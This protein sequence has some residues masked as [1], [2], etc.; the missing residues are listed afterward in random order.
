MQQTRGGS[1]AYFIM[2]ACALWLAF[3]AGLHVF[4]LMFPP[5]P[6]L[7]NAAAALGYNIKAAYL[8]FVMIAVW[9]GLGLGY[10]GPSHAPPAPVLAE[11]NSPTL[12]LW[13]E[14]VGLLSGI[15]VLYWPPALARF[16]PHIEAD[17]FISTLW[18]V[19]CGQ[20]PYTDFEFLYGPLMIGLAEAWIS[21]TGFSMVSYYTYYMLLQ[22]VFFGLLLLVLQGHVREAWKRYV[23]LLLL[24]PFVLDSLLGLNWMALRYF[25][26]P[27]MILAISARPQCRIRGLLAGCLIGTQAALSYEYGII[28]LATAMALYGVQLFYPGRS[29]ALMAGGL[30]AAGGVAVWAGLAWAS[31]G[32]GFDDYLSMT[33]AVSERSGA[34]GLGQF[35][36]H[37]TV[38]TLAL[39]LVLCCALV[40]F[41]SGLR[42]LGRAPLTAGDLHLIGALV[43]LGIAMRVAL[44][45]ADYVHMAIPFVPLIL[46]LLL[47]Q[48]RSLL[49]TAP[50]LQRLAI[51]A[52]VVAAVTHAVGQ[53]YPGKWIL[54]NQARGLAQELRGAPVIGA[55]PARNT[56][57]HGERFEAVAHVAE[58]AALLAEPDLAKRPVLFYGSTWDWAPHTGVCPA[59]YSFYDLLYANDRYPHSRLLAENPDLLIVIPKKDFARLQAGEIPEVSIRQFTDHRKKLTWLTSPHY[60]QG[61]FENRAEHEM[62]RESIGDALAQQFQPLAEIDRFLLL[63]RK[64]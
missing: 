30:A 3:I 32:G 44:Q 36:F 33:L 50:V 21:L 6:S 16:G 45:R 43:F 54:V 52:A 4:P 57:I 42:R 28:A 62:W 60:Q 35:A 2:L 11:P 27:L 10:Y 8:V 56:G 29:K 13:T 26:V 14:R 63:A 18:R 59:G 25:L 48:P 41:S 34:L 37:W 53:T 51:A 19:A 22:L 64:P 55:I 49:G 31:T 20:A 5:D 46:V 15:A 40:M 38:H 61:L 7:P 12:L 39:T 23:V 1:S 47:N 58:L 9:A 24:L 17:Y